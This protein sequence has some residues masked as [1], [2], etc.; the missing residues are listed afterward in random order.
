MSPAVPKPGAHHDPAYQKWIARFPC[1]VT[2][3]PAECAHVRVRL[4]GDIDNCLPLSH[5]VHLDLHAH[6]IKT[7]AAKYN[8]DMA[9]LAKVY[10][11]V[12]RG[13]HPSDTPSEGSQDALDASV[14]C[15]TPV[16]LVS[17]PL[18]LSEV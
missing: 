9:A 16:P 11:D 7:F 15:D 5:S 17:I 1:V 18:S 3:M 13:R 10:G 12:W 2:G 6:G 4:H 8:L 14:A